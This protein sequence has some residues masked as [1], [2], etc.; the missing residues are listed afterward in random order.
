MKPSKSDIRLGDCLDVMAGLPDC[1][2]DM[3]MC[4]L[5]YGITACKWDSVIPFDE[6]WKSYRR[7]IKPGCA[8]ALFASQPF[9]SALVMSAADLFKY[10]WI[11]RKNRGSNFLVA[12]LQP[13]KEHEHVLVFGVGSVRYFPEK[14]KRS[15][16]GGARV[17]SGCVFRESNTG[18]REAYG[19]INDLERISSELR[20]PSS[21]R[22]CPT[23]VGF[24]PTQKPVALLE[25]LIRTY[26]VEGEVVLD[27][28]MGSGSTGVAC[29]SQ[30]RSFIGIEK[31]EKYFQVAERRI[32][33]AAKAKAGMLL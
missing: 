7:L 6:L 4:D 1:S 14:E 30:G 8:I 5:P 28:C 3:V 12:H 13:M 23:Q 16:G 26:T 29:M 25:Y 27:N 9:S 33:E 19:G 11:W 2:I 21:V 10:E 18:K 31:D 32:A 15:I 17:G 20:L 22:D 24:H